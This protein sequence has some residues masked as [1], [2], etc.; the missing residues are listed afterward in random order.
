MYRTPGGDVG[1]QIS[2]VK[3][4]IKSLKGLLLSRYV[5]ISDL[6]RYVLISDLSRYV[7]ISFGYLDT[8]ILTGF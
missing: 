6:S 2:G 3:D 5:L 4:D 1:N 8:L 7:L